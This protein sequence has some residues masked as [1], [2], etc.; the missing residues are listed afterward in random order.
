MVTLGGVASPI[1]AGEIAADQR[2]SGYDLMSHQ[3]QAMQDDDT[4]NP[5]MEMTETVFESPLQT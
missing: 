5:G 2:R 3:T 4:S 1:A